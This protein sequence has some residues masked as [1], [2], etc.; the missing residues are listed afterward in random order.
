MNIDVMNNYDLVPKKPSWANSS[1]YDE[2]DR[3]RFESSYRRH[4]EHRLEE[5]K[6]IT[7]ENNNNYKLTDKWPRYDEANTNYNS[8]SNLL[9]REYSQNTIQ[10]HQENQENDRM[11]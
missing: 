11:N 1:F 3:D 5:K 9:P 6:K 7:S 8:S 2:Y 4:H 10:R